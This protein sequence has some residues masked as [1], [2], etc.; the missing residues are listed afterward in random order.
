MVRPG[1]GAADRMRERTLTGT[2][3]RLPHSTRAGTAPLRQHGDFWLAESRAIGEYLEELIPEP[4]MLPPDLRD[5]ARARQLMTWMRNDHEALR[6]ERP[7]ERI[8]YPSPDPLPPL[9]PRAERAA[10]DLLRVAERLGAGPTGCLF[11]G[12][13]GAVDVDLAFA[14]MRL[15]ATGTPMPEPT[16]A[17]ADAVWHRPSVREYVEHSRPRPQPG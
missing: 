10:G 1:V 12:R 6:Q 4:R 3:P 17:Y 11:G 7:A 14:L 5:R 2:A 9:S 16:R 13:F 15:V 8:T